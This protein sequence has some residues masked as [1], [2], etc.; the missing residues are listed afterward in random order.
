MSTWFTNAEKKKKKSKTVN[1]LPGRGWAHTDRTKHTLT[2]NGER[3]TRRVQLRKEK[4]PRPHLESANVNKFQQIN[5]IFNKQTKII[6]MLLSWK[7]TKVK[8]HRTDTKGPKTTYWII[9]F[10]K[11]G[12][13]L[14]LKSPFSVLWWPENYTAKFSSPKKKFFFNKLIIISN[15]QS[16]VTRNFFSRS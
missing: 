15:F 7:S 5:L 1:H 10:T 12:N 2:V 14:F 16:S 11:Y 6:T 4:R 13:K 3:T 9:I 8:W